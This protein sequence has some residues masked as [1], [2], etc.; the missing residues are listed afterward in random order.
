MKTRLYLLVLSICASVCY[1]QNAI[2]MDPAHWQL[3]P[4]KILE[5]DGRICA[6]GR[7]VL[8]DVSFT[9][10]IVDF[11]LWTDGARSFPGFGF[12]D[13]GNGTFEIFYLRT[14]RMGLY[15]DAVQYAPV[16]NDMT[17][18][19]LYHGEGYCAAAPVMKDRWI[20]IK[21]EINGREAKFY[22]DNADTPILISP[23]VQPVNEGSLVL[24]T[25]NDHT[26][27]SNVVIQQ[28]PD[29]P[30]DQENQIKTDETGVDWEISRL[31]ESKQFDADKYPNFYTIHYAGWEAVKSDQNGLVNI[32]R[33]R[34][35]KEGSNC[36]YARKQIY[37]EKDQTITVKF[38]Y[39]DSVKF[40]LNEK[41]I[42]SG[43]YG[44]QSRGDS[45]T[46]T[47]G[48]YDSYSLD[49]KKGLNEIFLVLNENF[50]GWG[51]ILE[52]DTPLAGPPIAERATKPLWSTP[53]ID[54]IPES[55][56][57]DPDEKVI[58][59]SNFDGQFGKRK[60]PGSYITKVNL[61]GE[62]LAERWVDG[63]TA[64]TG[65]TLY[66]GKLY[67][68]ERSSVAEISIAEV[69]IVN[70][71]PFPVPGTFP[72][73]IA[74][75]DK[76]NLYITDSAGDPD[77]YILKDGQISVWLATD[78]LSNMNGIYV[79]GDSL[80]VGDCNHNLLQ[81]VDIKT[82]RI[83]PIVSTG[84]GVIDGIKKDRNGDLIISLWRGELYRIDASGQMKQIINTHGK[85]NIADF[86]YVPERN[87]IVVPAFINRNVEAIELE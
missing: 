86:E 63:L 80:V 31:L 70:R 53:E 19:Q 61:D 64:T 46:G 27:V 39:S 18:W 29:N 87:A 56:V 16:F 12:R 13:Q 51:F 4:G 54:L 25:W 72:N 82:K 17:C 38:G 50:G 35:I 78:E 58:Y 66:D 62:V 40:F 85:F 33:H 43:S 49:L 10:A 52:S 77:L 41:L 3:S 71:Y 57:Y 21:A 47:I 6:A 84:S 23:L 68:V 83:T 42:Y 81:R 15:Q 55:A 76:G 44:F 32:T 60:E 48:T 28:L 11:D 22:L 9:N 36:V 65:I 59:V 5:F 26:Y 79:D 24:N 37:S 8:K 74:A 73:D 75:D 67:I 30:T 7:A 20:H 1:G 69:K 45:F 34:K 14:H 2:E